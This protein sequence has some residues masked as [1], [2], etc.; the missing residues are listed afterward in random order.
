[1]SLLVIPYFGNLIKQDWALRAL[2]FNTKARL[3]CVNALLA[4]H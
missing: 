4:V 2:G 1:M 3:L